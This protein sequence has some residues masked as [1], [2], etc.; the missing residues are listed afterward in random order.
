MR[1]KQRFIRA[2]S[3]CSVGKLSGAV[4]AYSFLDK[5]FENE[6]CKI[7]KLRRE[8]VAT[9][10]VPRDRHAEL[11]CAFSLFAGFLERIALELRHLQRTEL[12]EA[13]EEFSQGQKGSSAMP[14]KK[15]PISAENL[16]GIA[17]LLRSYVLPALENQALWHERDISHS[18]VERV[19]L[20][21]AFILT[22]YALGRITTL[23]SGLQVNAK[24]MAANMELSQGV[25][26]SSFVLS[27][28]VQAGAERDEAYKKIQSVSHNLKPGENLIAKLNLPK[29]LK[30]AV[31]E[32]K[33]RA[34][35][36]TLVSEVFKEGSYE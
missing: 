5:K 35:F 25:L 6:V 2:E 33:I 3:T 32:S 29:D 28:M 26:Y 19:I 24:K 12:L 1:H 7:L 4:G 17:R 9:Q 10:V 21:D 14:H 30:S 16:T 8:P 31:D 23:I 15:N 18:S 11:F 27:A 36:K 20:P 22:D 13:E 34:R